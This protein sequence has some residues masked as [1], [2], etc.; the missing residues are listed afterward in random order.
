MS[1]T[2]KG[3]KILLTKNKEG[4]YIPRFFFSQNKKEGSYIGGGTI[5][6]WSSVMLI[7]ELFI[8]AILLSFVDPFSGSILWVHS[9]SL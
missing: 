4:S 9:V 1:K 2:L 5:P 6:S 3:S 8:F 7:A